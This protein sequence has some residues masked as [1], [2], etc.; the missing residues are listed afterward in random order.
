[1][2]PEQNLFQQLLHHSWTDFMQQEQESRRA[3]RYPPYSRL[4]RLLLSDES[5]ERLE[6]SAEN[7]AVLLT[8]ATEGTDIEV[9][10]PAPCPLEKLQGR[11][12]WHVLLRAPRVQDLQDLVRNSM[13]TL[14]I[15][16][17][18]LSYDPDPLE[19]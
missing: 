12:R 1:R 2:K 10:G 8:R 5:L 14:E 7:L 9:M 18:R 3:F 19:L 17:T 16:Q 13:S 6:T 15:G 4:L 11:Y